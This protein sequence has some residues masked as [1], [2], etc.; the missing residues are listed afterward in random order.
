MVVT[1]TA[2]GVEAAFAPDCA[3]EINVFK[4]PPPP[5]SVFVVAVTTVAAAMAAGFHVD[6]MGTPLLMGRCAARPMGAACS[7]GAR[8][9]PCDASAAGLVGVASDG[10]QT[11]RRDVSTWM[12]TEEPGVLMQTNLPATEVN[13]ERGGVKIG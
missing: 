3:I 13:A 7:A 5:I 2:A 10:A 12:G 9:P 4:T 8:T 1:A 6:P 11:R